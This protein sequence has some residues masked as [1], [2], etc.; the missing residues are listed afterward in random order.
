MIPAGE[1]E[2][3]F[4]VQVLLTPGFEGRVEF[5]QRRLGKNIPDGGTS[6]NT[7]LE[8]GVSGSWEGPTGWL[9]TTGKV[10]PCE[11]MCIPVGMHS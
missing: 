9:E 2:G 4:L 6:V 10:A 8:M 1:T 3:A 7:G 11:G 5:N